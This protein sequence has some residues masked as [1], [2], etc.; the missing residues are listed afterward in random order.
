MV[1]GDVIMRHPVAVT[2]TVAVPDLLV[3]LG[4]FNG[5]EDRF[6]GFLV[7]ALPLVRVKA[8]WGFSRGGH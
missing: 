4:C 6:L 2:A 1:V 5:S 3:P 7:E 8:G